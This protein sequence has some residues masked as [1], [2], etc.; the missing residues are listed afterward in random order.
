MKVSSYVM[1]EDDEVEAATELVT[2]EGKLLMLLL[3][4][5]HLRLQE[6]LKFLLK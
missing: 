3:Y 4:K 6:I 2:R 5:K 1:E